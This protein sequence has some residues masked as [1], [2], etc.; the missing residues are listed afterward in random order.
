MGRRPH[1]CYRKL[2]KKAYIK[3]RF[4]RSGP[5]SKLA[6]NDLGNKKASALA[7]PARINLINLED[8]HISS[9][10]LEAARIACNKHLVKNIGK[11]N[12]HLRINKQ[13]ITVLRINKMM[14]CA[15]ADR[16]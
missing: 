10:A 12:F 16:L 14:S 6:L 13:A 11:D 2:N 3:S 1:K 7:F 4:C 9:E 15:G 8:E 5:E